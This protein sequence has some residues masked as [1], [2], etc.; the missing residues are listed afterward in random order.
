MK[1][2]PHCG[3][4]L[5]RYLM[6]DNRPPGVPV[7]PAP[8]PKYDQ[9]AIWK[10]LVARA[11][12]VRGNPPRTDA[13]VQGAMEELGGVH[14]FPLSTVVHIAFDRSVVPTGGVLY[15]ATMLNGRMNITGEKLTA[16]G[17]VVEGDA[18]KTVSDIPVGPAFLAIDYWGG[19]KQHRRWHLHEPVSI[20]P[21][22]NGNPLFMD[23]NMVAFGAKW[24]DLLKAS[25]GLIALLD[26]FVHGVKGSGDPIAV[27][28]ALEVS[29]FSA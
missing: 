13:L 12:E 4:D 5:S 7:A 29:R 28:L 1:F 24:R 9:D 8:V 19:E 3:G 16:M 26:S 17:Y 22:R 18:V 14:K 27:P 2:C 20:D 11:S 23:E 21:S 25:D 6:A 15:R 10:R